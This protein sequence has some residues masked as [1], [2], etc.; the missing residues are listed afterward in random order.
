MPDYIRLSGIKPTTPLRPLK[1]MGLPLPLLPLPFKGPFLPSV[2]IVLL[3]ALV[4]SGADH[5]SFSTTIVELH[6]VKFVGS[7]SRVRL[8]FSD[9]SC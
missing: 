9:A 6:A 5:P 1:V 3:E 7:I 8:G 4:N 2:L